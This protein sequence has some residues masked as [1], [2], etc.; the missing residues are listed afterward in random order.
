M[1][2][3]CLRV[4]FQLPHSSPPPAAVFA[5]WLWQPEAARATQQTPSCE[6]PEVVRNPEE[7]RLHTEHMHRICDRNALYTCIRPV[8]ELL[9]YDILCEDTTDLTP[10]K[11]ITC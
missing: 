8:G 9:G 11:D 2:S 4:T 7:L 3:F 6:P 10:I 1:T 5:A